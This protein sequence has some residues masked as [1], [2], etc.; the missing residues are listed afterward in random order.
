MYGMSLGRGGELP[1]Q[2]LLDHP[3][4]VVFHA[5]LSIWELAGR[6]QEA[7]KRWKIRGR[8]SR[9]EDGGLRG[10]KGALL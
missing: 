5:Q 4:V 8:R 7:E 2:F 9:V 6:L 10:P 3:W 1:S